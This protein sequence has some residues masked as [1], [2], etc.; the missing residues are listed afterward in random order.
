VDL[1]DLDAL[2]VPVPYNLGDYHALFAEVLR[3]FQNSDVLD[4]PALQ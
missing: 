4:A 2:L 1:A 3:K